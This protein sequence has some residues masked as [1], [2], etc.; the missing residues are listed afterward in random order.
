M[1]YPI[2]HKLLTVGG[3]LFGGAE[4]WS[5][6]MRLIPSVSHLDVTQAQV[7]SLTTATTTWFTSTL[8]QFASVHSLTFAKLA[9]IGTDGHYPDGEI[10]YEHVYSGV[11]GAQTTINP[12]PAQ[13]T[14]AISLTTAVPRGRGH[15]G[16]FYLPP[17]NIALSNGLIPTASAAQWLGATRTWLLAINAATDVGTVG[18]ITALGSG[19]SRVVTGLRCGQV[20]DT[21]RRRRRQLSENYQTLAL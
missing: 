16:R 3:N 14:N 19:T 15:I 2:R 12:F 5:L 20:V 9:P 21:Q 17:Q 1:A 7:D 11:N 6:S 10:S 18:V 13:C 8:M 4:Q